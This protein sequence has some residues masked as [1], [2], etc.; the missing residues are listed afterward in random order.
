MGAPDRAWSPLTV[1][2]SPIFSDRPFHPIRSSTTRA[3]SSTLQFVTLPSGST[4][5]K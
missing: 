3:A 2:F 5:S 1:T 4:T